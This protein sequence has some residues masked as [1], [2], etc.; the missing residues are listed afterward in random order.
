MTM[1]NFNL[2]LQPLIRNIN[3]LPQHIIEALIQEAQDWAFDAQYE[4]IQITPL[5]TGQLRQ[6]INVEFNGGNQISITSSALTANITWQQ[7][8]RDGYI[9]IIF[10]SHLIYANYIHEGINPKTGLPLNF[11][12]GEDHYITKIIERQKQDLFDRLKRVI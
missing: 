10:S 8:V 3:V 11:Q 9:E 4:M 2:N 7:V 12:V 1:F 5:D 6:S